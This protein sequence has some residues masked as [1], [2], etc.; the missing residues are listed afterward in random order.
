M[1]RLSNQT[2]ASRLEASASLLTDNVRFELHGFATD[3]VTF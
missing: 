3:D 2:V 1:T